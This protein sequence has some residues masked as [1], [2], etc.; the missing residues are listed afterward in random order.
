MNC[1]SD[2][3]Q[4]P[5]RELIHAGGFSRVTRNF[6]SDRRRVCGFRL[7]QG[8]GSGLTRVCLPRSDTTLNPDIAWYGKSKPVSFSGPRPPCPTPGILLGGG[9]EG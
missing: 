5:D 9:C 2:G 6:G 7:G 3:F 4:P 8:H 1:H